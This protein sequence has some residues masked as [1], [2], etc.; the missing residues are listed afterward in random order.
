LLFLSPTCLQCMHTS[1]LPFSLLCPPHTHLWI[2]FPM[3]PVQNNWPLIGLNLVTL[4]LSHIGLSW[5]SDRANGNRQVV[6]QGFLCL[7]IKSRAF[8]AACWFA[9]QPSIAP[10]HVTLF[11]LII[12]IILPFI[13]KN[14]SLNNILSLLI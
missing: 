8:P 10:A 11:D 9:L 3:F 14:Q 5:F 2:L 4:L 12:L 6:F 7:Y 1:L 13:K